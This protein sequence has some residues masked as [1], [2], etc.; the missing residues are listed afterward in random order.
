MDQPQLTRLSW[1]TLDQIASCRRRL[2]GI[3]PV[4]M[5]APFPN[6]CTLSGRLILSSQSL[7]T[8][9]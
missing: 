4:S 5:R 6:S 3:K 7:L 9:V 8:K 1:S 2:A